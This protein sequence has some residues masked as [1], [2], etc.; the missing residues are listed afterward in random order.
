MKFT[1]ELTTNHFRSG[2]GQV[3]TYRLMGLIVHVGPS[4]ASGHYIAYVLIEGIWYRA[5]DIE[6]MEV[7]WQQLSRTKAYILVYQS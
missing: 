5:N 4:I 7:T 3:L 1:S 6:I 2:N